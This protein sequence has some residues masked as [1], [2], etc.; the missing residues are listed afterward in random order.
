MTLDEM[1]QELKYVRDYYVQLEAFKSMEGIIDISYLRV[2]ASKYN[3]AIEGAEPKLVLLYHALYIKG[4]QQNRVADEW[5]YTAEYIR[6]MARKLDEYLLSKI[7]QSQ[8]E[9]S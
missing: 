2:T 5:H 4:L 7:N 1:R 3:H 6:M 9:I 8:K